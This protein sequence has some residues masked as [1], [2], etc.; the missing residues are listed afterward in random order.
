MYVHTNVKLCFIA[1][2]F[3]LVLFRHH[4][5]CLFRPTS[6]VFLQCMLYVYIELFMYI[7]I[8]STVCSITA[9]TYSGLTFYSFCVYKLSNQIFAC[10][11]SAMFSMIFASHFCNVACDILVVAVV[12]SCC[13]N[14]L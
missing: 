9:T 6:S 11:L 7:C 1:S 10:V 2:N 5:C 4:F 8:Y 13:N 14:D 3:I 12:S